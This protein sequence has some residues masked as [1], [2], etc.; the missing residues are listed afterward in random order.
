MYTNLFSGSF[1]YQHCASTRGSQQVRFCIFCLEY[2]HV[3]ESDT[4]VRYR[5]LCS[6]FFD[7]AVAWSPFGCYHQFA[8]VDMES[9]FSIWGTGGSPMVPNQDYREDGE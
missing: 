9:A 4:W 8:S 7:V 1:L 2:K 6:L 3:T 5:H